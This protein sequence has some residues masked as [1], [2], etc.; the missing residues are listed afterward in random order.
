MIVAI[1]YNVNYEEGFQPKY[2]IPAGHVYLHSKAEEVNG[3]DV[4]YLSELPKKDGIYDI[5]Y[6]TKDGI[7][8]DNAK[9]YFWIAK[10]NKNH[11]FDFEKG[12]IILDDDKENLPYVKLNYKYKPHFYITDEDSIENI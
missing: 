3:Y 2:S 1:G 5:I 11:S 8:Y 7:K 9:L 6:I 10:A 12:L 4:C